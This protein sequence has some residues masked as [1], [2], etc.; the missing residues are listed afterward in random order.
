M[1]KEHFLAANLSYLKAENYIEQNYQDN[2]VSTFFELM[3][4]PTKQQQQ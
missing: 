1:V 4:I 2:W 3:T